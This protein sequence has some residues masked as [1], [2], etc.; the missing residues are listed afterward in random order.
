MMLAVAFLCGWLRETQADVSVQKRY[1]T[2]NLFK[3]PER[4]EVRRISFENDE[5]QTKI[6][7]IIFVVVKNGRPD[8]SLR[9]DLIGCAGLT[10]IVILGDNL[11]SVDFVVDEETKLKRIISAIP[12]TTRIFRNPEEGEDELVRLEE[13]EREIITSAE[14]YRR[15]WWVGQRGE[16]NPVVKRFEVV[17]V[18]LYWHGGILQ[19]SKTIK[20]PWEKANHK[21]SNLTRPL[22]FR[23][24]WNG[25]DEPMLFFR[26][27]PIEEESEDE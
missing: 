23:Q 14:G 16:Y 19:K 27:K 15:I 2:G 17:G 25:N 3:K 20:G 7:E 12:Q 22:P 26:L 5:N 21:Q 18:R 6:L 13:K 10:N 4:L 24:G 9:V 11:G 8:G 1:S